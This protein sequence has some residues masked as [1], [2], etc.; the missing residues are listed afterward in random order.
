MSDDL[1]YTTWTAPCG[2]RV[3]YRWSLLDEQ[4]HRKHMPI[5][6]AEHA[7]ARLRASGRDFPDHI[8][9]KGCDAHWHEDPRQHHRKAFE[10]HYVP[11]DVHRLE[12]H[13][14]GGFT[15]HYEP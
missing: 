14:G 7:A 12:W 13:E 4:E 6:D 3:T 2:C 11:S 8:R 9:R 1:R 5:D 10:A 15:V